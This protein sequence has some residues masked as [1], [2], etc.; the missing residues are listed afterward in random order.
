MGTDGTDPDYY[1]L[2]WKV[3]DAVEDLFLLHRG[4]L[5]AAIAVLLVLLTIGA[6][7]LFGD[8]D[9]DSVVTAP[10]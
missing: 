1:P 3:A 8:N 10:S 9:D 4:K 6:V 7:T 5:L 2:R